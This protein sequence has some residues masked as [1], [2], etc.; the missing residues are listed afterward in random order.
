MIFVLYSNIYHISRKM[1]QVKLP[2]KWYNLLIESWVSAICYCRS[3][4]AGGDLKSGMPNAPA[5]LSWLAAR[6]PPGVWRFTGELVSEQNNALFLSEKTKRTDAPGSRFSAQKK[7][8]RQIQKREEKSRYERTLQGIGLIL[9]HSA[10][11]ICSYGMRRRLG[12]QK[13]CSNRP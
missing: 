5:K 13:D 2:K 11:G 10:H 7:R 12:W 8:K 3:S 6:Q 9:R 4:I 1:Y